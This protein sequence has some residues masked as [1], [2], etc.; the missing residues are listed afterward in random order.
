MSIPYPKRDQTPTIASA[1][2]TS[3]SSESQ[4]PSDIPNQ[5]IRVDHGPPVEK[6][7]TKTVAASTSEVTTGRKNT[8]R[9][10]LAPRNARRVISARDTEAMSV[11]GT[12]STV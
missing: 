1:G 9:K 12:A 7:H 5:P 3:T 2:S 8:E 4:E 11:P 6:I 10:N